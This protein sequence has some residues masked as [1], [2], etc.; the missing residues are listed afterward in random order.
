MVKARTIEFQAVLS[1]DSGPLSATR[2]VCVHKA[3]LSL[4]DGSCF[5]INKFYEYLRSHSNRVPMRSISRDRGLPVPCRG[6]EERGSTSVPERRALR[7]DARFFGWA[8]L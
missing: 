6:S 8:K 5:L 2:L 1:L 3:L 4:K 7:D